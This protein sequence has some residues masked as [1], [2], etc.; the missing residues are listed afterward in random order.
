MKK[1]VVFFNL[2]TCL[3]LLVGCEEDELNRAN[4]VTFESTDYDFGVD[5]GS[6]S[7]RD[8]KIYSTIVSG[9][10]RV[11]DVTVESDL[12]TADPASYQIPNSITL[13]A[14]SNV[15]VLPIVIEDLN[16]G[17]DGK[18]LVLSLTPKEGIYL[19]EMVT[20]NIFQDCD[21]PL[22][23][24]FSFDGYAD[25][26]SWEL[27]NNLGETVLTGG[28]YDQGQASSSV[29][30]C[31]ASGTYTFNVYDSYGDGLTYPNTGRISISQG[32]ENK[33]VIDGNYGAGTSV[34]FEL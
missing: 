17:I 32:A 16:I 15:G 28:D 13:P 34:S 1:I 12:S 26:T 4:Y 27:L 9:V 10:D 20:L 30:L 23:I 29:S 7:S 2:L 22:V 19:G 3:F 14:N 21:A 24:D 8:L 25:E 5:V 11:F 6:S 31:L 18:K 33:A